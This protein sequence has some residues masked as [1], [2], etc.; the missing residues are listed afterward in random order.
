MCISSTVRLRLIVLNKCM[1]IMLKTGYT[2]PQSPRGKSVVLKIC[3]YS[4]LYIHWSSRRNHF[5]PVNLL[6]K[7]P[8][9]TDLKNLKLIRHHIFDN[10]LLPSS[11]VCLKQHAQSVP[12]F[13]GPERCGQRQLN[14][15]EM[16]MFIY[17]MTVLPPRKMRFFLLFRFPSRISTLVNFSTA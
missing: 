14:L 1:G 7:K 6:L 10:F 12:I 17:R 3:F 13:A 11:G 9:E 5:Q 8:F 2:N 16:Q 15:S 4:H